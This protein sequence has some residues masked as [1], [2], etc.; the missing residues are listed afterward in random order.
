MRL[1]TIKPNP[2]RTRNKKRVGRG[3]GSGYGKTS[4]RG[5]KG[6]KSRSGGKVR[7]GFEGGQMPLQKRVPK[8]GFTSRSSRFTKSL[9]LSEII[10]LKKDKVNMETLYESKL[11]A[12]SIR[13]VKV[14]LDVDKCSKLD[15]EGI[16][17]STSVKKLIEEA[18]GLVKD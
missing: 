16:S 2:K 11:I 3:S 8:Y 17:T 18:G 14:F 7:I 4:G 9:R 13:K 1:N 10:S 12:K 15:L 5:H 6:M